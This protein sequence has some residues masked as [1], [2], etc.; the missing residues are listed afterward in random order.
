MLQHTAKNIKLMI[1]ATCVYCGKIKIK[2]VTS[3]DGGAL[4]I[5]KAMLPFLPKRGLTLPSM[6]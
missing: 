1:K 3:K 5:H 2:F 6:K 4:D